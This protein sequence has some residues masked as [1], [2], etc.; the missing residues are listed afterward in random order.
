MNSVQPIQVIDLR[1]GIDFF[2]VQVDGPFVMQIQKIRNVTAP[3]DNEESQ[4]APAMLKVTLTD[5]H[6]N[7]TAIEMERVSRMG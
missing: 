5:G 1:H 7:C 4:T 3:K 2:I 6:S